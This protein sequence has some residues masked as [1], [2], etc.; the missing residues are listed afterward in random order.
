[1]LSVF[2]FSAIFIY[3]LTSLIG[4]GSGKSMK[5]LLIVFLL[6]GYFSSGAYADERGE[7]DEQGERNHVGVF[8]GKANSNVDIG[9]GDDDIEN[10]NLGI[11]FGGH[12]ESGLGF[13][14]FYSNTV[15]QEESDSVDGKVRYDAQIWGLLGNYRVGNEFYGLVQVGYAF[16]DLR[17]KVSGFASEK[18]KEEGLSYGIGFGIE[19]G[20]H[21]AVEL[22]YLVLPD[23][24]ERI[25]GF[26]TEI[27]N[28]LTTLGYN[29]YF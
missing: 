19:V 7:P 26:D 10:G 6:L 24:Y 8:Y 27:D 1:M 13:E 2:V 3:K 29:W 20:K 23:I 12:S 17:A 22:K 25:G 18:V 21:G 11:V 14:L 5:R 4:T 28:D 16:I 9:L 15:D